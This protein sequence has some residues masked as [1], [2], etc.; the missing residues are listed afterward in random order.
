MIVTGYK[1]APHLFKHQAL[2]NVSPTLYVYTHDCVVGELLTCD[3]SIYCKHKNRNTHTHTYIQNL[4]EY[5]INN[6]PTAQSEQPYPKLIIKF[7]HTKKK[8]FIF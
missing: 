1:E 5:E 2:I 4:T 7:G 8:T 3:C 6:F